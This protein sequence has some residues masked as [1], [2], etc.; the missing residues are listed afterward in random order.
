MFGSSEFAERQRAIIAAATD[1]ACSGQRFNQWKR[2]TNSSSSAHSLEA[3]SI[4]RWNVTA[5]TTETS[6]GFWPAASG[7]YSEPSLSKLSCRPPERPDFLLLFRQLFFPLFFH[8][9]LGAFFGPHFDTLVTLVT[10]PVLSH[11]GSAA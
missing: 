9:P 3:S 4:K 11:A 6:L 2:D 10:A 1:D 5:I 7:E 8:T